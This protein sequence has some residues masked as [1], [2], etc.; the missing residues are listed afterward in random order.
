MD[1]RRHGPESG[2]RTRRWWAF[3]LPAA[4]AAC[5]PAATSGGGASAAAALP[6]LE[7]RV[8]ADSSDTATLL[9]LARAYREAGR[10]EEAQRLLRR[11]VS[12]Q[13]NDMDAVL[14]LGLTEEDLGRYAAADSLYRAYIEAGRSASVR[15]DLQRRL[16]LLHRRALEQSVANAVR[17]E[18]ARVEVAVRPRTVAVFPF[19]LVSADSSLHPLG[20]ALAELL[21]TDL[22]Q[23]PRLTVLERAQMQLLIDELE[24]GASGRVDPATAARGGR[25]LGAERVVDGTVSGGED[26]LQ[27]AA[28]VVQVGS[29]VA[30]PGAPAAGGATPVTTADAL[31]RFFDMEKRL[32]FGL[33]GSLG[34]E[35]TPAERERVNQRPTENLQA[36]LAYGRGLEAEDRGAF[37][38]AAR[39]YSRAA[40]LDPGFTEARTKAAA[41]VAMREAERI[42]TRELAEREFLPPDA[43]ALAAIERLIPNPSGRSPATEILGTEGFGRKGTVDVIIRRPGRED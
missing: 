41:A 12:G 38:E 5:A 15:R 20:R 29:G 43:A 14:L 32:A 28:A 39:E 36:I 3:L 10:N 16:V 23:T 25:L 40:Q 4:L 37:A 31:S 34:V 19:D 2:Q 22:A 18:Q 35:L 42:S 17:E 27:L 21:T 33:Y 11:V 26:R 24:L 1:P 6:R 9:D 30:T 7:A 13:P 8:A